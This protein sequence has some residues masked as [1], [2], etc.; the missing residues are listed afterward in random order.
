MAPIVRGAGVEA[1]VMRVEASPGEIHEALVAA[2]GQRD[3]TAMESKA[4]LEVITMDD[5]A[6]EPTLRALH[7][8]DAPSLTWLGMPVRWSKLLL[9]PDGHIAVRAWPLSLEDGEAASLDL[10]VAIASPLRRERLLLPGQVLL[11]VPGGDTFPLDLE[12]PVTPG[13]LARGMAVG[14][15]VVMV[16]RPRFADAR[17]R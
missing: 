16:F 14:A 4:G 9:W 2:G 7:P 12:Q 11:L 13:P 10:H 8:I 3:T 5:S 6:L 17:A 1:L 15:P